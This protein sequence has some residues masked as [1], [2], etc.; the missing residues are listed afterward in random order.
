MSSFMNR[1]IMSAPPF[2]SVAREPAGGASPGRYLPV[3]TPCAIGD[4]TICPI[5][6]SRQVGTTSASM[7]RHSMEYCG[8]DDTRCTP[9]SSASAWPARI[10]AA[11]HSL[12]PMYSALPARTTSAKACIVSSSGVSWSNRCAW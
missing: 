11:V 3:R 4:Q 5:P 9:S 8:C 2:S 10:C 1:A 12:T 6:S 7:T